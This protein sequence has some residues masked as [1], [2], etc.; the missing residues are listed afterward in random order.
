MIIL[1]LIWILCS[2]F[3]YIYTK[4]A[5]GQN[6]WSKSDRM[7]TL[8]TSIFGPLAIIAGVIIHQLES[9]EDACW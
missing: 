3:F 7:L 5:H 4:K 6:S 1:I 9:K 8:L 2:I